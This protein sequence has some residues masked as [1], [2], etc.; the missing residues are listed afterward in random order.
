MTS[1]TSRATT[2][3]VA[4]GGWLVTVIAL[5]AVMLLAEVALAAQ[6]AAWIA[7]HHPHAAAVTV[8]AAVVLVA[9]L[10]A[11][12]FGTFAEVSPWARAAVVLAAMQAALALAAL[13]LWALIL[14]R[15]PFFADAFPLADEVPR[16]ALAAGALVVLGALVTPPRSASPRWL[17][18]LAALALTTLVATALWLP[19]Y[20]RLHPVEIS[21]DAVRAAL[22]AVLGPALGLGV[23]VAAMTAWRPAWT[24]R[25]RARFV[26][27][28]LGAWLLGVALLCAPSGD[29]LTRP[30]EHLLTQFAP[31]LLGLTWFATFT[32]IALAVAHVRSARRVARLRRET[33][34]CHGTI[35][36]AAPG[37]T[38]VAMHV[39]RGW[40]A[41]PAPRCLGFTL[42]TARG[43]VQVPAGVDVVAP[44]PPWAAEAGAGMASAL[45]GDGDEVDV[46]GFE[47]PTAGDAYRHAATPMFA[48][49]GIAVVAPRRDDEPVRRDALLRMWQPCAVL[50]AACVV[51]ATPTLVA[52]LP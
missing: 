18:A 7:T 41:G 15:E 16:P 20:G 48:T 24:R 14:R 42:R 26:G 49:R 30:W 40:L 19:I 2:L 17:V 6:H 47:A 11:G 44:L 23:I 4:G 29:V 8:V 9:A 37:N 31:V 25:G 51:S 27:G 33:A 43:E 21:P 32:V 12:L 50:L 3:G 39:N 52:F 13:A 35:V 38:V 1:G 28:L 45:L 36:V 10:V 5:A 46:V 34:T 22:P